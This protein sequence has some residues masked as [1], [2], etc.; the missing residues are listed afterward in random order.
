[1]W[2]ATTLSGGPSVAYIKVVGAGLQLRRWDP[3]SGVNFLRSAVRHSMLEQ[4]T[5]YLAAV[6]RFCYGRMRV[7]NSLQK[8]D[9]FR[10]FFII[11]RQ[12]TNQVHCR[13]E[14]LASPFSLHHAHTV[15]PTQAAAEGF[16]TPT[17]SCALRSTS[18]YPTHTAWPRWHG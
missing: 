16:S 13:S 6:S 2:S 15:L 12:L 14:R 18:F 1:M 10:P 9:I 5:F 4:L 8:E 17:S 11:T 3:C 7:I